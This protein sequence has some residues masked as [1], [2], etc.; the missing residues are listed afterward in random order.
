MEERIVLALWR[1]ADLF[2]DSLRE[3]LGGLGA[4]AVH[5]NVADRPVSEAMRLTA[6]AAPIDACLTLAGNVDEAGLGE[7]ASDIAERWTGWRVETVEPIVPPET[8][9]GERLDALANIA[10]LRKPIDQPYDE[11]RAIWQGD[12]TTVAIETQ[13]TF[14]YIQ[15]RVLDPLRPGEEGADVVAV[16]EEHF[17]MAA[18]S[19]PHAFYGS[20][21]DDAELSRRME[22]M[23]ASIARFGAAEG[24][25]LVPTSRYRWRLGP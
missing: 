23:F 2:D 5:V 8:S 15:N 4:T 3:R 14:G 17:P 9:D 25:D 16:V 12:H 19:D 13:G 21:G 24:L 20:D 10:L 1:P 6:M 7:L 11:W 22:R 18:I